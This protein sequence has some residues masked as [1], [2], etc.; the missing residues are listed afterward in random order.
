[1][2]KSFH[3]FCSFLLLL[4]LLSSCFQL[5]R[6]RGG[7]QLNYKP[8][9]RQ[10]NSTDV[11]L[12]KGYELEVIAEGLTFPTAAVEDGEGQLYV[13][14]SGYSYGEVFIAP[15]L[16]RIEPDGSYTV[17]MEGSKNG[18]WT[19]IVYHE[20]HFYVA[21]GGVLEGGKI[22]RID[23][24][25]ELTPLV[26][27][28]PSLGDHHTNGPVVKDGYIYFGQGTATNSGVVG[29]D[30]ADFGW[31]LRNPEFHDIPCED[32][33]LKGQNY[34]SENVLSDTLDNK[35]TTGAFVPFGK[36]TQD[37]QVIP[38]QIPCNG[39]IMRVPLTGGEMELVAW[40]LRNP[41][42][43]ALSPS[44]AIYVTENSYDVRGSRPVWGTGDVL[45]KLE[46]GAW[47]GWPD[48]NSG[49]EISHI[50]IP[51]KG[52]PKPLL[53]EYPGTP[54]RPVASL[55]V[56]SSSNGMD[57]SRSSGF[58]FQGQAFIAQF[59]DMAPNVGK[60]WQPVGF[61]VVRVDV[62]RGVVED[63]AVNKGK[64]DGPASWHKSGGLERPVSVSFS[65]DGDA[66]YIVDFGILTM[67]KEGANPQQETGVIWKVTKEP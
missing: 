28:L 64:R 55:G 48:Y 43:L 18:P 41:Y 35:A 66:M 51:G 56:H 5:R 9:Q 27:N 37:G 15:R 57:F 61:K 32:I 12:P 67:S 58:G 45:W 62:E 31:L 11:L 19:G 30:N 38:G 17:L 60:V 8:E 2:P 52:A 40:G 44:G 54:P 53:A 50:K 6:S 39:S 36:A 65:A 26:E 47:Y 24:R 7:G 49:H 22:L 20:D 59:G 21:E 34:T 33:V 4:C 29:K 16:L 46:Q 13:I 25:G 3:S 23:R 1:M 42:G 14:E 63:F 10:V